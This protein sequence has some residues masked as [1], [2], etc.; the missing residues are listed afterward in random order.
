MNSNVD[1]KSVKFESYPEQHDYDIYCCEK[2]IALVK[3]NLQQEPC[4][5]QVLLDW[6]EQWLRFTVIDN[7]TPNVELKRSENK[8]AATVIHHAISHIRREDYKLIIAVKEVDYQ[9]LYT[10]LYL[11]HEPH[12][13][14]FEPKTRSINLRFERRKIFETKEIEMLR[15]LGNITSI[16]RTNAH[17]HPCA[18]ADKDCKFYKQERFTIWPMKTGQTCRFDELKWNYDSKER[19][20]YFNCNIRE[21]LIWNTEFHREFKGK[22]GFKLNIYFDEVTMKMTFDQHQ[23][24]PEIRWPQRT[25]EFDLSH[26][27]IHEIRP[28][29]YNITYVE[30]RE[31][32]RKEG[33]KTDY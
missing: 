14:I 12:Y 32:L 3:N 18:L 2:W 6:F 11:K 15:S 24:K 17:Q 8:G 30:N 10:Q 28:F 7:L 31:I 27:E 25:H 13:S 9:N 26:F 21:R 19:F 29:I 33:I 22:T 4:A 5:I 23:P 20:F 16:Y 1:L